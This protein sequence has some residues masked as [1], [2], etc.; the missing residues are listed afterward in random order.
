MSD[1]ILRLIGN[2]EVAAARVVGSF[3]RYRS[4]PPPPT[5]PLYSAIDSHLINLIRIISPPYF[6]PPP[7]CLQDTGRKPDQEVFVAACGGE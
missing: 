5:P 3:S 7:R 2:C 4:H 6:I 1:E